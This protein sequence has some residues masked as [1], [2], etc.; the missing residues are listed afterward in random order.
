MVWYIDFEFT[1]EFFISIIILN[2]DKSV[3]EN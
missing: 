1:L 3:K 2:K